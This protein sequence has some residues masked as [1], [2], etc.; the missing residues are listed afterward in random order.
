[1]NLPGARALANRLAGAVI[2]TAAALLFG[3]MWVP[4]AAA[5]E[6]K[7]VT[8]AGGI[9][10]WLVEDHSIPVVT[11]RFAFPGGA[12]LDPPDKEGTA[13]MVAALLDEGAGA[14]DSIA[15]HAR[16][17][18]LAGELGFAAGHD[19]F[20][21]S[22]RMLKRNLT[23][24][25]DLLRVALAEPRFEPDAVERIRAETLAML[26]RQAH[27]PRTLAGR[28]WMHDAFEDHPYGKDSAGSAS[29]VAA[30]TRADLA[31][32]VARHI[33]RNGLVIAAV[34]DIT[35]AELA[36]LIEHVFGALPPGD[37]SGDGRAGVPDAS[38]GDDGA[39][40]VRRTPVPQSAV[41]FGQA[42]PKRADPDWY[43]AYALN[44]IIGGGGF[45]GR[46]MKEIRDKR[47]LAYGVSTAL[48]PYRHAGL[49]LGTIA[50]ENSRVAQSIA[51]IRAEWQRMREDGPSE[52]ELHGAQTYLAGSF[53]LSLDSTQHIASVLV[54]M[55]LDKLGIDYLDR[56]P[57]LIGGVTLDEARAVAR[58]LFDPAKLS[59]AVVGDPAGLETTRPPANAPN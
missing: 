28:L 58:R 37:Q 43:A 50:T 21:G 20:G 30:I 4:Q 39:L 3:A 34:G 13:S 55:Q 52:A 36:G 57:A 14:Y 45:R 31:D 53:P 41:S 54:Q 23:E 1:M 26:A 44:D 59:F 18:D 16:L 11:L 32:F 25:A 17:D 40:V 2:L 35:E 27:N 5:M 7:R 19:E 22:L 15:Y 47:G 51:L 42:G 24:T 29:G 9:E 49:I 10:A 8:G 6:I 38:P 46:L 12:A 33:H 56:R 48:V